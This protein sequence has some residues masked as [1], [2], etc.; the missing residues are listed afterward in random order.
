MKTHTSR[1]EDLQWVQPARQ[2]RSQQTVERLLDAAEAEVGEKGYAGVSVVEIAARAGCSVGTVYR[3]FRDKQ[4]LC[5][6]LDERWGEAFR[7]TL[8]QAVA[9][10]RWQGALVLEVLTGYVEF[11]LQQ[12]R[13]RGALHRAALVMAA[14]DESFAARQRQ[15]AAE[16]HTRLRELLLARRAEIGHPDPEAAIEFVLEQLRGMLVA[17]HDAAALDSTLFALEDGDFIQQVLMSVSAYLRLEP[18]PT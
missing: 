9:P 12:A 5:H 15:L 14:C 17:R 13:E 7:A 16:L 6:A 1:I 3:R 18:H 4:A 10:G 8:E 11:S 2:L